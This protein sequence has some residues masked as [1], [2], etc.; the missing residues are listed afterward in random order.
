MSERYFSPRGSEVVTEAIDGEV[1]IIDLD[2]GSY[3]SLEECGGYAWECFLQG[4]SIDAIESA[5]LKNF[6]QDE[7]KIK[8][9]L[10]ELLEALIQANLVQSTTEPTGQ[11]TS[12]S[13]AIP[14][15]CGNFELQCYTD[16]Q[17]LL[18]LDPIHEV[19]ES[20]WPRRKE[21]VTE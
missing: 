14:Q 12:S 8:T 20:G 15:S 11:D 4:M 1:V 19:E 21:D 9:G 5:L 3:Y 6:P 16:M 18:M 7:T 2:S 13:P 10:S 17:E